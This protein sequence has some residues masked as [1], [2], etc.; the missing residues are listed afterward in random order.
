M[1]RTRRA[2]RA[3]AAAGAAL[4][5][6]TT[7][8]AGTTRSFRQTTARDF[9]EGD[10]TASMILPTG[11]IV[12]GMKAGRIAVDAA[13]VWCTATSPDGRTVY[14]GTGDQGRIFALDAQAP[15]GKEGAPRRVAELDA[16][17]VSSLVVR[18]DGTLLAGTT[19]GGRIFTVDPKTGAARPF[20]KV[21]AEHVWALVHDAKSGVTY[22]GSGGDGKVFAIDAKGTVRRHWDSGDKQIVSLHAQGD[23]TLLAGS[24]D[25]GILYR[26]HGDGRAEALHDFEADEVRAITASGRSTYLAVNAF[27]RAGEGGGGPVGGGPPPA[28]GTRITLG[29]TASPASV[30]SLPRPG[31]VKSRSAVYRLD[32]DGSVEQVFALADGY[33]TALLAEPNG[34]VL[35]ASGTQGKIYRLFPDRSF[36]LVADLSERQALTLVRSAEGFLVGTGDIGGIYRVR[37]SAPG[38]AVYLSKVFDA[39]SF[40]RWGQLRWTGS[41][42]L[43]FATRSGNTAKP[44]KTWT[45]WRK[46][47]GANVAGGEGEG[48]IG[49]PRA[50]YVQFRAQLPS[51]S[52]S[53]KETTLYYLPQN[54]RPRVTE[55]TLAEGSGPAPA[56]R[57][58]SPVLK[59]RFRVDNP[60]GDELIYR[61]AARQENENVWRPLGGPEPLTKPELDWNTESVPDGKYVVRVWT[62]DERTTS[63]DRALDAT[64]VSPPFLVDN[65]KPEVTGLVARGGIVQGRVQDAASPV[66]QIEVSIDGG[67]WRPVSPAD[68]VL[69][70][71]NESFSL[72]LSSAL[73]RGLHVVTVRAFDAAENVGSAR[74]QVEV[75]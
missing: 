37:A 14:F 68:G 31:Q 66:S 51:R 25:Q 18:P 40:A 58:H 29:G 33:L 47:E 70:Q 50:R 15:G 32:E 57:A 54:Q 21:G 1:I 8:H 23:G 61:V 6:S 16:A 22:A 19:P 56:P 3:L 42:D 52:S 11:E 17:W 41:P 28:K 45:D 34:T 36:A 67:D 27:D 63:A 9:E 4:L 75:K 64:F 55:V 73:P 24:S 60:D 5:A 10:A 30:G 59:L 2:L 26:V 12:P 53:L 72:R 48:K 35:A 49:S 69:D 71:R 7:L 74:V 20:A 39:E 13:F 44:D 62:S 43:S 38:E 46:L 65:T